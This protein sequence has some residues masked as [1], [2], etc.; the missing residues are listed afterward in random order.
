MKKWSWVILSAVMIAVP[1]VA[2]GPSLFEMG[3]KASAQAGAFVARA[4]DPTAVF[5]NPAGLVFQDNGLSFNLTYLNVNGKYN[6][7]TMG[8][9]KDQAENFFVPAPFVN[10]RINDRWALGFGIM[11]HYNLATEW[12]A[13][14]PGRFVSRHAKLLTFTY[15]PVVAFKINEHNSVSFGVDF[16]DSKLE[17]RRNID[18]TIFSTDAV[19]GFINPYNIVPS[20][21]TISTKLRDQSWGFN[22]GYMYK[23]DPWS[24]GFTYQSKATMDYTGRST[25]VNSALIGSHAA[26]FQN[27]DTSLRFK[28]VPDLYAIGFAY[29]G[30]GLQWEFDVNYTRWSQWDQPTGHFANQTNTTIHVP[31]PGVGIVPVSVP[32][33]QDEQFQFR[34][35]NTYTFRLGFAYPLNEKH[36]LRWGILWDQAPVPY[37]TSS[38]VLPDQGRWSVQFGHGYKAKQWGLDWYVMYLDSMKGN[39]HPSN[40][41]RYNNNGLYSYP[42]MPDGYYKFQTILAGIQFNYKF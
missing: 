39:V 38:P 37:Q 23:R 24:F 34:W 21:G 29:T 4:D 6:S 26:A 15:R 31:V 40:I 17:L 12:E 18:T 25:F 2:S 11:P 16:H 32:V 27:M 35:K 22:L 7:P 19:N 3:S 20:E 13:D 10:W 41:Y 36:E 30:K 28:A 9:F 14:F 5:Y 8:H 42:M 33:V 1:A